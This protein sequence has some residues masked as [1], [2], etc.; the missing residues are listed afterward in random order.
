MKIDF[1]GK[2]LD[3]L[4]ELAKLHFDEWKHLSPDK[5]LEDRVVK[6]RQ[7]AESTDVPFM[8]VATENNQLIGSSA[9]VIEDMKTRKDL[10][11]WLASVFV[12]PQFRKNGIATTLVRHIENEAT[13][14][15]IREL[16]L[17]TEHART[18]Y[19]KLGWTELEQCQYQGVQVAIMSKHFTV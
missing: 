8:V 14:R 11:P 9:L 5:T 18:L 17:Y 1:L 4:P 16:F 10:S 15:G 7:M 13:K 12:K 2:H 3:L 6:L 19:T